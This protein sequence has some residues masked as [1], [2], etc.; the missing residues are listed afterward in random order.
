[1]TSSIVY[2]TH[3]YLPKKHDTTLFPAELSYY[4]VFRNLG[5]TVPNNKPHTAFETFL[6]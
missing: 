5:S 2:A 6:A 4:L 1:M 3:L